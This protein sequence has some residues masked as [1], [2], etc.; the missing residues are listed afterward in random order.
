M[1][2]WKTP[3]IRSPIKSRPWTARY[4]HAVEYSQCILQAEICNLQSSR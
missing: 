4:Q 2:N 1:I 3:E